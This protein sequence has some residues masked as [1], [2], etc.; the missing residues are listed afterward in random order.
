VVVA[1]AAGSPTIASPCL[2][3]RGPTTGA[4]AEDP[5]A[6]VGDAAVRDGPLGCPSFAG[7]REVSPADGSLR[8][9]SCSGPLVPDCLFARCSPG[10]LRFGVGGGCLP[11]RGPEIPGQVGL[12]CVAQING[13]RG[14]GHPLSVSDSLGGLQQPVSA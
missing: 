3:R 10:R 13:D 14:P 8:V 4:R 1:D 7:G 11:D 5:D 2:S 12:V 6:A 9:P